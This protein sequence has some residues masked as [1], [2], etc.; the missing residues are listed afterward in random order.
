MTEIVRLQ[1]E[2]FEGSRLKAKGRVVVLFQG[3]WSPYCRTFRALYP[4]IRVPK[5]VRLAEYVM[6]DFYEPVPLTFD[7]EVIPTVIAFQN[8]AIAWRHSGIPNRG[9]G[10]PT[11]HKIEQWS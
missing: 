6:E 2:A 10:E 3:P 8:G 4:K 7:I 11:V 1:E 5:G 9:L